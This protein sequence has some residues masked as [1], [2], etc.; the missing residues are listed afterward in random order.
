VTQ[1]RPQIDPLYVLAVQQFDSGRLSEAE[2]MFRDILARNPEHAGCHYRIGRIQ[3]AAGKLDEA[4][5]SYGRAMQCNDKYPEGYFGLGSVLSELRQYDEALEAFGRSAALSPNA[6]VHCQIGSIFFTQ[7][8]FDDAYKHFKTAIA[9][10]PNH[11]VTLN[12]FGLFYTHVGMYEEAMESF[13]RALALVPG[14]AP[15]INN[16]AVLYKTAGQ[17]EKAIAFYKEG[18]KAYPG[19]ILMHSNLM[20]AMVY[21]AHVAPEEL[22]A[23]ARTF[24]QTV[25]DPLRRQRPFLNGREPERRLRIGY[26]SPDFRRHAVNYFFEPLLKHHDRR[27]FE[28]FGYSNTQ[29]EDAVTERLKKEFD[30]WRDI[31]AKSDDQAA[32]VI[33]A[34]KIDI[35]IDLTGHTDKNRL[36]VFARKPAPVQVTW[37]G[38]PA[39]TGMRAMDYR[40]SDSYAEPPGL[41]E[42][43]NVET[44]WRLPRIFC[45]YAGH[46][47]NPAVAGHPPFED[48]GYITFGCFN[49]F[50]KVTDDVLRSWGKI[51][52]Q[53]KDSR[54]LLEIGG[55]KSDKYR[56]QVE[57]RLRAAGIPL[58][59]VT[60]EPRRPEN[61]FVLYNKIDIALDPFPCVGG[62]TSMD[63]LWM[64]V[65][66]VTLAGK[67]FAS[68]MGV[69]ILTNAGLPELIAEDV[70]AYVAKITAL[71]NDRDRLRALRH[72]LREKVAAGPLMDQAAFAKDMEDAYRGMWRKWCEA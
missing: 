53:V 24:G 11:V 71:A 19:N 38:F 5:K 56:A 2:R 44:L 70:G 31:R 37:L 12:N 67:H 63:S 28:I 36:L 9:Y 22:T 17:V 25:A 10:N 64:G 61:Q 48:N 6:E 26:V 50:T 59:R 47:S 30:H 23:A 54:L 66:F 43:L 13:D 46:E 18:L 4:K 21:A 69:S 60:L 1:P 33:E 49:N 58:E 3:Q 16:R 62:T 39:T 57:E 55:L 8:K 34:D 15:A 65:P 20:F 35:L 51:I 68:R 32:D 52:G 40:L 42:H 41:T 14:Y 27:K 29:P 72:G 45:C 7:G